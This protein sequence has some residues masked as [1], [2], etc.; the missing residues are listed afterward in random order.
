MLLQET[1][2]LMQYRA[3]FWELVRV[4]PL[5]FVTSQKLLIAYRVIFN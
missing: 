2:E 5:T 1:C 4:F 3:Y